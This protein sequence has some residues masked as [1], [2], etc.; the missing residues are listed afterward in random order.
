MNSTETGNR[1]I[2]S[3]RGFSPVKRSISLSLYIAN[4]KYLMLYI[5]HVEFV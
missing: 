5:G 4:Y 2:Q 3:S 1:C